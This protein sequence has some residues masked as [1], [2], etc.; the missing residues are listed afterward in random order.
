V[1][2]NLPYRIV[3]Y[4]INQLNPDTTDCIVSASHPPSIHPI[5][6]LSCSLIRYE[7]G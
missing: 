3:L 6:P 5:Q 2:V 1:H 4:R 7:L